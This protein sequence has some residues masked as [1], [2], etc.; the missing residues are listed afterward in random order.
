MEWL[1]QHARGDILVKFMLVTTRV[2]YGFY[3]R[4]TAKTKAVSAT[5]TKVSILRIMPSCQNQEHGVIPS[6]SYEQ[7]LH[8]VSQ[9]TVAD[10]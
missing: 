9:V 10:N 7:E 8:A 4:S 1:A 6:G 5:G 2:Q 3:C